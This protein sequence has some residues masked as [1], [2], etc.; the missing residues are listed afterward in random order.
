MIKYRNHSLHL[1]HKRIQKNPQTFMLYLDTFANRVS[2]YQAGQINQL[3]TNEMSVQGEKPLLRQI[4]HFLMI[5]FCLTEA[6]RTLVVQ[7]YFAF[8]LIFKS[9]LVK[10]E[11]NFKGSLGRDNIRCFERRTIKLKSKLSIVVQLQKVIVASDFFSK[12]ILCQIPLHCV[13]N[14]NQHFMMR[15]ADRYTLQIEV[16]LKL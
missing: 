6:I 11:V 14:P 3:L 5:I 15:S 1:D 16:V 2:S 12:T 4:M 10:K 13:S 7:S 9:I 8:Y